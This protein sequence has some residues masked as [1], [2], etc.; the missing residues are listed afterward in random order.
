MPPV[1]ERK[2]HMDT[3]TRNHI[4][5]EN[6]DLINCTLRRHRLLLYALHL[7][8]DDVYQELAIAALQAI[9]TYDDRR[10]DSITVHIWA[11]LQY[12][13]LTIKRRNKPHGIMACE[14]FAPGVLSLELSEDYGYPAVA[15]TGS[16]DDLIREKRLR[17]ALA[18][19][20]PQERRAVLDYLDGMKP[21][22]RSEKN[23]F[24]AALEKLRDFYLSTYRTARFGL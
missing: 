14:G 17:Q 24:D 16:D 7:E 19:L 21:A 9:D 20:E 1:K 8:L 22:R 11:K 4:F 5:M 12:A 10:C 23:S 13:V 2:S 18:R 3:M 6:I 15:E